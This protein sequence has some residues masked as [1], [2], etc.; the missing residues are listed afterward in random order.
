LILLGAVACGGGGGGSGTQQSGETLKGAGSSL[1]APLVSAWATE[2]EKRAGVQVAYNAVG[3]G[4]GVQ[5]ITRRDVDFGATDAPLTPQQA[6]S[7]NGVLQ[8]PW[9]LAATLVSYNVKGL[10]NRLKLSGPVLADI[11]LGHVKKWNDESIAKLNRGISLP[12]TTI[13]PI[14]RID[15][16]GD[17]YAF[18]DYLSKV[19]PEW[20]SR[21]GA[22]AQVSFPAG[23]G[24][25]GNPGMAGSIKRQDGTIGY[26]AIAYVFETKLNY[27]LV[28]NKAGKFPVPGIPSTEAAARTVTSLPAD[29]AVSI[30][31]PPASEP[32]AYPISTFTYALAPE[33][34]SKASTLKPFLT[35]AVGDG[36]ALGRQFQFAPLPQLVVS[37]GQHTIAQIHP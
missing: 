25:R 6:R 28:Q 24:G 22:G 8:I 30:T 5:A 20:K 37:A 29:N 33:Q 32:G 34:S 7:A 1:V 35:Y 2:Y 10:P 15:S 19:S 18:T 13:T 21:I 27:A 12:D 23:A 26:L 36:Q 4:A 17:T 14:F 31:D 3:S 16:S 11:F 9:A